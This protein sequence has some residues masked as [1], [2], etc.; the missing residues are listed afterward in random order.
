MQFFLD[1]CFLIALYNKKDNYHDTANAIY[2]SLSEMRSVKCSRDL[3]V[4]DY[5]ITEVFHGLQRKVGIARTLEHFNEISKSYNVVRVSYPET[6]DKAIKLKLLPFCS[7]KTKEPRF[8]LVDAISLIIM[9]ENKIHNI[10]SFD[11]DFKN[12]PFV[13]QIDNASQLESLI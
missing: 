7:H 9:D 1:A 11:G 3:Y 10:I 2:S 4:T 8:G 5:I 6:V 13:F 12:L